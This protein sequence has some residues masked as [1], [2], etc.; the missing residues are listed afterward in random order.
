MK[1]KPNQL[2]KLLIFNLLF[3]AL[4]VVITINLFVTGGGSVAMPEATP[5]EATQTPEPAAT[6]ETAEEAAVREVREEVGVEASGLTRA[7]ELS[8]QFVDGY[9]LHGTVFF[10]SAHT[11]T[12][13][14]TREA[15]PFWCPVDEI[16]Y[17]R[18]WE[19]D[20]YWLPLALEGKPFRAF[21]AFDGDR[22]LSRR[23]A[24]L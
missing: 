9:A 7:G 19:D 6:P 21:F 8:F 14:A 3:L 13:H 4:A 11:G 18:M 2:R 23:I 20:R 15:D 1:R 12:P 17:E 5:A 22:M 16:P 10:A 24:L